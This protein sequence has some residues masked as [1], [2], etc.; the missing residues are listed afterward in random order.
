MKSKK[1]YSKLSDEELMSIINSNNQSTMQSQ[2][3][4]ISEI[5]QSPDFS[6]MSD[7]DLNKIIGQPQESIG[8]SGI[9]QDFL[10]SLKNVPSELYQ[11]IKQ[12]PS[13][14][15]GGAKQIGDPER[16]AR[17]LFSG[18]AG[19]GQGIH[20]TPRYIAD[21][22]A[23]KK[24]IS[25]EMAQK[26]PLDKTDIFKALGGQ[27]QQ[28]G[29][30][31]IRALS[32]PASYLG[33][34]GSLSQ[35]ERAGA[36]SF[37]GGLQAIGQNQNPVSAAATQ[38][39]LGKGLES[40]INAITKLPRT[41]YNAPENIR[42]FISN[43]ALNK[44][45]KDIQ[46]G[47]SLT[48]EQAM[49]NA[50]SNYTNIEG[51]PMGADIGTLT[52]NKILQDIYN[53]SSKIPFSGGRSQ[54]TKLDKQLFDKKEALAKLEY[55][56]DKGTLTKQQQ[57]YEE[58]L[59]SSIT[60]L[61]H[62]QK[63]QTEDLP[64]IEKKLKENEQQHQEL[65]QYADQAPTLLNSFAHPELR[66]TD[67]LKQEST[68]AFNKA[69]EQSNNLYKPINDFEFY[70]GNID[71]KS[72]FP[73]YLNALIMHKTEAAALKDIF[74]HSSDLGVGVNKELDSALNFMRS[75]E[76]PTWGLTLGA[77]LEHT[78]SLG[79]LAEHAKEAGKRHEASTLMQMRRALKE[80]VKTLLRSRGASD[81]ADSLEMADKYYIDEVLP[82]YAN[83]EI[84]KSV[85]E[86]NYKP[87]PEKLATA[88]HGENSEII[89]KNLSPSARKVAIF[90]LI[91]KNAQ[92]PNR[93]TTLTSKEI[94]NRYRT[95]LD[96]NVKATLQKIDPNL[97][98]YFENLSHIHNQERE[99]SNN[100]RRLNSDREHMQHQIE[101]LMGRGRERITAEEGL[102]KTKERMTEAEKQFNEKMKER[103][104]KQNVKTKSIFKSISN[105][106]PLNAAG[107]GTALYALGKVSMPHIA[108]A[109][110]G[111]LLP[112]K[113]INKSLTNP[114]LLKHYFEQTKIIPKIKSASEF[115]KKLRKNFVKGAQISA[116]TKNNKPLELELIKKYKSK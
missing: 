4:S 85:T 58:N 10:K 46:T 64:G 19:F 72:D 11:G 55:E 33:E 73:N 74:G 17:N 112:A 105:F 86:K 8:F 18:F 82:W 60:N 101:S 83:K 2:L 62:A 89:L 110:L 68:N 30:A 50:L 116:Y 22:L 51:Q 39:L 56:K 104:G 67:F 20:N 52:G 16:L 77:L 114:E 29:D 25:P 106:S 70:L 71:T 32:S 111:S 1:D 24:L 61:D 36:R 12:L 75:A 109:L 78:R 81:I 47:G 100:I 79:R 93:K 7:N 38:A 63:L 91:N 9:G 23:Q 5:N 90:E 96:P 44:A 48:P 103:F 41:I 57:K 65:R 3:P 99:T 95:Q 53:V 34:A 88:I 6:S 59:R 42:T 108:E 84:R 54:L 49:Q 15:Y 14:I 92:T 80:D 97:N 13:E 107:L 31:L 28:P 115:E 98:D 102:S 66:H 43:A 76:K 45:K 27:G 37:A 113:L 26:F 21:Y 87:N 69:K 35:L 94:G 40:G